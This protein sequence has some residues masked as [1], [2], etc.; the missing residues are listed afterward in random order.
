MERGALAIAS[1]V[2]SASRSDHE[3]CKRLL[4][5]LKTL[6]PRLEVIWAASM[7]LTCWTWG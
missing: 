4:A 1:Y 7:R 2:T 5:E 6:V 3:G